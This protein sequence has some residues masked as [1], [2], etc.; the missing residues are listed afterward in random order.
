MRERGVDTGIHWQPGHWFKLF[1]KCPR[2]DLGMTEKVG[3]E[4][5][6]LP[7]H[8]KMKAADQERVVDSIQSYF[9]QH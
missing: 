5:F 2:G 8:S 6:S 3:H 7:L 9:K 4:I 1:E